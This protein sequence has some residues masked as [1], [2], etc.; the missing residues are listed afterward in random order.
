MRATV[1]G[2]L[3]FVTL[4]SGDTA[5]TG[6]ASV[7][8]LPHVGATLRIELDEGGIAIGVVERVRPGAGDFGDFAA[9]VFCRS[10]GA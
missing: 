1:G 3:V 2:V 10:A 4:G 7:P 8:A 6:Q 9:I 5:K